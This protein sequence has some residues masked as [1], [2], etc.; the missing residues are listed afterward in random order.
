[1]NEEI[2]RE[3]MCAEEKPEGLPEKPP[4]E[5]PIREAE[6][7]APKKAYPAIEP[8]DSWPAPRPPKP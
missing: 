1:M 7:A 2:A 5:K 4:I 6:K 8:P 3:M